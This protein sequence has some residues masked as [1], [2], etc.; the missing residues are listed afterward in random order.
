MKD[1]LKR[2]R[3]TITALS[4]I[5]IGMGQM[6]GKKEYIYLER[7]NKVI[8]PDIQKLYSAV[9][10]K[11]LERQFQQYMFSFGKNNKGDVSLGEW[12]K[13]QGYS[14]L[15]YKDW[16][17]Y[18]LDAGDALIKNNGGREKT[19]RI[20]AF[21]K[22]AYGKPYV[23]GSSIKGMLRTALLAWEID[24][25]NKQHSGRYD[26]IAQE[27]KNRVSSRTKGYHQKNNN[28]KKDKDCLKEE[29]CQLEQQIL[30]TLQ[31]DQEDQTN[32][33]NDKL[34][35]IRVSD[36]DALDVS[37]LTLCQKVDYSITKKENSV[38]T[39]R[40][41]L[42]PGT[43]ICFDLEIDTS[44]DT[45]S[46]EDIIAAINCYQK[47]CNEH[48][49]AKFHRG[50][51]QNRQKNIV[52]LGGGCGFATKT[53]LYALYEKEAV[54]VIDNIYQLTLGEIYRVHRHDKDVEQ[55]VAPHI[56]KCTK[57]HGE[58]YDMGMARFEYEEY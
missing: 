22:D 50:T 16:A 36:S 42:I 9:R 4:P 20:H 33:V 51:T 57:Y 23:P 44:I 34:S 37:K 24:Q 14:N 56:C 11:G 55:G 45:Y 38:N 7:S 15:D 28:G 43:K 48:F 1:F 2:Y 47:I 10:R 39:V 41:S 5:H 17:L 35:G 54:R 25:V 49:Y 27:I 31:R 18:Q 13:R 53:V 52:W 19:K 40:E 6:I 46:I 12:L 26:K 21:I 58:L 30:Y 32:A 29:T 3:V 8:I